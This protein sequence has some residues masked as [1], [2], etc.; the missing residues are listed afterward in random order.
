MIGPKTRKPIVWV[1]GSKQD[2]GAFPRPIKVKLGFAL[3]EAQM[4]KKHLDAKPLRGFGGAGV[5][6]IVADHEGNA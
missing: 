4:G 1:G 5:L 3:H 6:E 2:L